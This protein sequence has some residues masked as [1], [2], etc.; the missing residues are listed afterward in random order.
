MIDELSDNARDDIRSLL[1][2][3]R[4]IRHKHNG[5]VAVYLRDDEAVSSA[6][7]HSDILLVKTFD[8]G[9]S[10]FVGEMLLDLETA[11]AGDNNDAN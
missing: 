2:E 1:N 4:T 3:G 7:Y 9:N 5:E 6:V 10:Q 11:D 8:D